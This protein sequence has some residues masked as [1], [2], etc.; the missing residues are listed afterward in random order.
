MRKHT[1]FGLHLSRQSAIPN[2]NLA[3]SWIAI[4]DNLTSEQK[5]RLWEQ[6]LRTD[7][8][9]YD[10]LNFFLVF[11]SILLGVVVTL[12]SKSSPEKLVLVTIICLGLVITI[13][14]AYT[15][16]RQKYI[17]DRQQAR[18]QE[19]LPEYQAIVEDR[20]RGKWPFSSVKLLTYGVPVLIALV[21]IVLFV[22]T[23]IT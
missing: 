15:Q 23:L 13:L 16:A 4:R 20:E 3:K 17:R 22:Y 7:E 18:T 21:W 9:F 6:H 12:F 8:V 2:D 11:E 5:N 19:V 10:R 1:L 14:W